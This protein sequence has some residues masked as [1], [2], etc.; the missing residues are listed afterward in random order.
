MQVGTWFGFIIVGADRV[1][2]LSSSKCLLFLLGLT[3]VLS[4]VSW[5]IGHAQCPSAQLPTAWST[6]EGTQVKQGH[7]AQR[8]PEVC[9]AHKARES[10]KVRKSRKAHKVHKVHKVHKA[11]KARQQARPARFSPVSP[12]VSGATL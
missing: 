8:A 4:G 6:P 12:V 10:R 2:L 9:K 7:K 1:L 11:H 5:R 3:V